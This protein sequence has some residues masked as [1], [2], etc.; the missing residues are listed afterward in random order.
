[1]RSWRADA[2]RAVQDDLD[3]LLGVVLERAEQ[4]LRERGVL[5]PFAAAVGDDGRVTLTMGDAGDGAP[6]TEVVELLYAGL[7]AQ[8]DAYRAVAFVVDVR[9]EGG[10]A[11]RVEA[12]HRD[13]GPAIGVVMPYQ[14]SRFRKTLTTGELAAF[15]GQRR[16]W[17]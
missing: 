7:R 5:H 17:D 8:R 10:D 9:I 2:P 12:E 3:G 15:E 6:T 13:G 1:M 11:V 14:R 16:V 4:S